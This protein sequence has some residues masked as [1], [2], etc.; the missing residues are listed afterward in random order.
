MTDFERHIPAPY[1]V[2]DVAPFA[3]SS[4]VYFM[5]GYSN[6]TVRL[7]DGNEFTLEF[8]DANTSISASAPFDV[9][10]TTIESRAY[11][12]APPPLKPVAHWPSHTPSLYQA[13]ARTHLLQVV[14]MNME[15]ADQSSRLLIGL[16]YAEAQPKLFFSKGPFDGGRDASS[17][18]V[19]QSLIG[20]GSDI[21]A[22][23]GR[24]YPARSF[25]SI[26]HLIETPFGSFFNKK[27]TQM[28]L[29]PDSVGKLAL[30]LPPIPFKYSLLNGP[31]PL[32]DVNNPEGSAIGEIIAAH[33]EGKTEALR[34][35]EAWPYRSPALEEIAEQLGAQP[36][37]DQTPIA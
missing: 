28:E 37:I 10:E 12:P 20:Q 13:Q 27:A 5:N 1:D 2:L 3:P 8:T 18:G 26:Y 4:A 31:I 29:Q 35:S 22:S 23:L 30:A 36:W 19:V 32:Y 15:S 25:F 7:T 17:Y 9:E 34:P 24:G 21:P 6:A 33:H 11:T 16:P 14:S